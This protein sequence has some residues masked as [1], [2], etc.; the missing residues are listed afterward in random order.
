MILENF[1]KV[2]LLINYFFTIIFRKKFT[3][4]RKIFRSIIWFDRFFKVIF[5]KVFF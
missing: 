3:V 2:I 1:K 5:G 4:L